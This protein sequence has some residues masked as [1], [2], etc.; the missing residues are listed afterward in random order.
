MRQ[1]GKI[2]LGLRR[3]SGHGEDEE[4]RNVKMSL[5]FTLKERVESSFKIILGL[6]INL[7][8]GVRLGQKKDSLC[9]IR[10]GLVT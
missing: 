6:G 1:R 3:V 10:I 4:E 8:E 9:V 7:K 2:E 5:V